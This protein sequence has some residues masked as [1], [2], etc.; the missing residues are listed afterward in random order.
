ME[1][2]NKAAQ[3]ERSK[4]I[5][6]MKET[7]KDEN[8]KEHRPPKEFEDKLRGALKKSDLETLKRDFNTMKEMTTKMK[9]AGDKAAKKEKKVKMASSDA[10]VSICSENLIFSCPTF[11]PN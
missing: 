2:G 11:W 6:R 9:E 4:L 1:S 8:S 10:G 3:A 5:N 7:P